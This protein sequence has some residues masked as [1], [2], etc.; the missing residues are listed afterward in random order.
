M[1]KIV[2]NDDLLKITPEI[3]EL[4]ILGDF[5]ESLNN[6]PI[7]IKTIEFYYLLDYN[8]PID[9]LP[10]GLEKLLLPYEK[11][12]TVEEI[13]NLPRSLKVLR[14]G[15]RFNQEIPCDVLPPKLTHLAF[16]HWFNQRIK[17]NVLPNSL[18]HLTFGN[19]F[20]RLLDNNVLPIN[21]L[22]LIFGDKFDQEF[23]TDKVLPPNLTHLT[24]GLYYNKINNNRC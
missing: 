1:L 18:T 2:C 4:Q 5:S 12:H 22:H 19:N 6:L 9:L 8:K 7:W 14:L 10:E 20:N 15:G 11:N 16:G 3:T 13:Q 23:M 21:L 24:F 17:L